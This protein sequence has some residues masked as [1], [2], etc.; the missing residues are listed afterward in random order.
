MPIVLYLKLCYTYKHY[1]VRMKTGVYTPQKSLYCSCI[2]VAC[3][4]STSPGIAKRIAHGL[5]CGYQKDQRI[6]FS[7]MAEQGI[8]S[9]EERVELEDGRII[10]MP[11]IGPEHND[12]VMDITVML[13][14]PAR[15]EVCPGR[16]PRGVDSGCRGAHVW[17]DTGPKTY[18][19]V[20]FLWREFFFVEI[21]SGLY[22][23][24]RLIRI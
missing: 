8:L 11:P 14:H 3:Y 22:R 16:Y 17:K 10:E 9:P 23:I 24:W 5:N 12:L 21:L 7:R 1:D 19:G 2:D 6:R 18:G 15:A 20:L 4:V 13:A